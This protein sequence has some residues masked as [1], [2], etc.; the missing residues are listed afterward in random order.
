MAVFTDAEKHDVTKQLLRYL[1]ANGITDV[2][3]SRPKLWDAA[4]AVRNLLDSATF[5]TAVSDAIDAAIVPETMTVAQKT[6]LFEF[7]V[8]TMVERGLF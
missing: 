5:R 7:V 4:Q 2:P 6:R 3:Y 8:T 1:K